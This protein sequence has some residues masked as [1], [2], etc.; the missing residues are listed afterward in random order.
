M[1]VSDVC[2]IML[3]SE[4][5]RNGIYSIVIYCLYARLDMACTSK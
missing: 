5:A 3:F 2:V 1:A 4:D